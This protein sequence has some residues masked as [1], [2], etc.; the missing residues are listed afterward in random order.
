MELQ[1]RR[2]LLYWKNKRMKPRNLISKKTGHHAS[3][4]YFKHHAA[5][6]FDTDM[7]VVFVGGFVLGLLLGVG[8]SSLS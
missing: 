8:V 7:V 2:K 1:L 4:Q 5:L 6:W 3:D